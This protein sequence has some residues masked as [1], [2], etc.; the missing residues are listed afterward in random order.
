MA[1]KASGRWRSLSAPSAFAIH[2]HLGHLFNQGGNTLVVLLTL[3]VELVDI[4]HA[5]AFLF[6]LV[7]V[8]VVVTVSIVPITVTISVRIVASAVAVP[9][10][11][12]VAVPIGVAV[13]ISV[14]ALAPVRYIT[15]VAPVG[16]VTVIGSVIVASLFVGVPSIGLVASITIAISIV[17]AAGSAGSWFVIGIVSAAAVGLSGGFH[18]SNGVWGMVIIIPWSSTGATL[19]RISIRMEDLGFRNGFTIASRATIGG[20]RSGS[21]GV[22]RVWIVVGIWTPASGSGI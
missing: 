20:R 17:G 5:E 12:A 1:A 14:S 8:V 9:V 18:P 7:V 16:T 11:V 19:A 13:S 22:S 4:S 15:V 6:G 3:F 10:S 21:F 2:V